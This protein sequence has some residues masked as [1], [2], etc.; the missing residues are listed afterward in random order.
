MLR[1][2]KSLNAAFKDSK[3]PPSFKMWLRR[4]LVTL[5]EKQRSNRENSDASGGPLL[6][7]CALA[8]KT[9][10]SNRAMPVFLI[11][12]KDASGGLR[13]LVDPGWRAVVRAEDV[14]FLESLLGDFLERAREQPAALFKQLSS[15]AV[16]PLVTQ[17]TGEQL[18][19]H[20]PLLELSSRFVQL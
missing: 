19:D 2:A 13:F 5:N 3:R 9:Q 11:V 17:E 6:Q 4:S 10:D 20:P 16:G 18:S 14:E 12:L 15:L 8:Y 1:R 7:F